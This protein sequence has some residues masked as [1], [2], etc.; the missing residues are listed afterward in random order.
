MTGVKLHLKL[1]KLLGK[2]SQEIYRKCLQMLLKK[3]PTMERP[4]QQFLQMLSQCLVMSDQIDGQVS[5]N[6]QILE[7]EFCTTL[8]PAMTKSQLLDYIKDCVKE[9]ETIQEGL[10]SCALQHISM[11]PIPMCTSS[12]IATGTPAAVRMSS[13]RELPLKSAKHVTTDGL[14][15]S[16]K[17]FGEISSIIS[18]EEAGGKNYMNIKIEYLV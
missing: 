6:G 14:Q 4:F 9:L 7:K 18:L 2:P 13:Y 15:T 16:L 12:T 11:D 17:N 5:W 3:F 8:H 10:A 1:W